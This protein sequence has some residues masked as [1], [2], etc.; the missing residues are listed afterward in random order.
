MPWSR[1]ASPSNRSLSSWPKN[2]EVGIGTDVRARCHPR[3]TGGP[4]SPRPHVGTGRALPELQRPLDDAQMRVDLE[5]ACLHTQRPR[6]ERRAGVAVHDQRPHASP[7]ELIGEHE[8][9]RAR[10]NDQDVRIH[11]VRASA[12]QFVRAGS[13]LAAGRAAPAMWLGSRVTGAAEAPSGPPLRGTCRTPARSAGAAW[14]P[15]SRSRT[16]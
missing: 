9:G 5:R 16:G 14:A 4:S 15:R 2:Q 3:D 1:S 13:A 11:V 7:G 8:P 12:I 6:L 10:A